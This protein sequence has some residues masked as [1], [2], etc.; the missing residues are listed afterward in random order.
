[1]T[2]KSESPDR[3]TALAVAAAVS[4]REAKTRP[5]T[6]PVVSTVT[7]VKAESEVSA[8]TASQPPTSK[9]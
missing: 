4:Q 9:T 5:P 7:E 8:T 1:M 3:A 2:K 6:K